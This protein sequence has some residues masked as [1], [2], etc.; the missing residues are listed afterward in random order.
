MVPTTAPNDKSHDQSHDQTS[1]EGPTFQQM[2][3]SAIRV[4]LSGDTEEIAGEGEGDRGTEV[5]PD[6]S[7][8]LLIPDD[9]PVDMRVK[10]AVC[11]VHSSVSLPPSLLPP[12]LAHPEEY[13]DLFI[14]LAESY[15]ET[16]E[17]TTPYCTVVSLTVQL[18]PPG[19]P[20]QALPLL[21]ALVHTER[22]N[23]A[24]VWLKHAECLHTLHDLDGAA[25]SY[26]KV[27]SLA[28]H[29]TDTRY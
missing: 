7:T 18:S 24:A 9:L 6:Q 19:S 13:G 3:S 27:L 21:S 10:L 16:G 26:S 4:S 15:T 2:L 11:L 1:S 23:Q 14:D 22:Y 28:P 29:H 12:V 5:A 17:N 20:S 8:E 25:M